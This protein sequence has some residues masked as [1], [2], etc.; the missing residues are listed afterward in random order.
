[1]P[2]GDHQPLED[3]LNAAG[4]DVQPSVPGWQTLPIR[5]AQ[6]PQ[7]KPLSLG[8]WG[9]LPIGAAAAVVIALLVGYLFIGRQPLHAQ[10][11]P[12]E[13]RRQN[14]DLTILSVAESDRETLYM[15]I[16]ELRGEGPLPGG[17]QLRGQ[18]L[19]KDRRLVLNLKAGD[20]VVKF[21]DIAA[22]I[23]PTSVRFESSDRSAGHHR[24]RAKL[25][26]RPG[27]GQRIIEAVHR[28][29]DR[30]RG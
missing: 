6:T 21:T 1:M 20:N 5:L 28:P 10:D 29:R 19:L 26:V 12:I 2:S 8:R 25:R 17:R 4:R 30:L 22:T 3:L 15:P 14:I 18:A 7:I 16:M 13:V 9:T 27:H 24:R 23:D 11:L